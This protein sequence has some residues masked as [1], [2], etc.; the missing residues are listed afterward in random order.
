M[1]KAKS[2]EPQSPSEAQKDVEIRMLREIIEANED[3][4][5]Q[6]E[7]NNEDLR[8][9]LAWAKE[10]EPL[11]VPRYEETKKS[12]E[13]AYAELARSVPAGTY[14]YYLKAREDGDRHGYDR[15]Y[16]E[17]CKEGKSDGYDAAY[18][19]G[20]K[21]GQLYAASFYGKDQY[22]LG[23]KEGESD[24]WDTGHDKG[25]SEGHTDG[26]KDG[27]DKG[28]TAHKAQIMPKFNHAFDF[29]VEVISEKEDSSDV[30]PKMLIAALRDRIDRLEAEDE[31]AEMLDAC[32]L[33][34]TQPEK[35][36]ED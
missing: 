12:C 32:G 3:L 11:N 13:A 23:Y 15:G 27:Y 19:E 33:L 22:D 20:F 14:E 2:N 21:E 10:R 26:K 1:R 36:V 31:G 29:A 25:Y 5:K 24:G 30:T 9:Q 16:R 8:K 18:E 17:G 35:P 7:L 4:R 28:Y 6:L 34:D